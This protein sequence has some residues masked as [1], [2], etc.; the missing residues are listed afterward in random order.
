MKFIRGLLALPFLPYKHITA[1]FSKLEERVSTEPLRNLC[2][3]FRNT[4]IT[5]TTWPTKTWSVYMCSVRTNNDCEGWH[6]R[7]NGHATKGSL[8][9]YICWWNCC[10]KSWCLLTCVWWKRE[11][12]RGTNAASTNRY[13]ERY[14]ICGTA[15]QLLKAVSMVYAP[16]LAWF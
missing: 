7:L 15:K 11:N 10:M 9:F 2:T 5:Y 16:K 8:P 3:Y 13:K 14:L 1:I 4:W 12:Y 6:R